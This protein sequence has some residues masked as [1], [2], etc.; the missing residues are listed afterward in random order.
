MIKEIKL[1]RIEPRSETEY[2][3][4]LKIEMDNDKPLIQKFIVL[5]PGQYQ[6][7]FGLGRAKRIKDNLFKIKAHVRIYNNKAVIEDHR[8]NKIPMPE[9]ILTEDPITNEEY[10]YPIKLSFYKCKAI[11]DNEEPIKSFI[12]RY[13]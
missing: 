3:Y 10:K 1:S 11:I 2:N 4:E 13:A 9:L 12:N 7:W 5:N 6:F 8:K